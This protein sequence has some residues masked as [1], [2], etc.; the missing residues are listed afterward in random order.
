MNAYDQISVED[1]S[2]PINTL[3]NRLLAAG[4]IRESVNAPFLFADF[5]TI[6]LYSAN[7]DNE[8]GTYLNILQQPGPPTLQ[9]LDQIPNPRIPLDN[10]IRHRGRDAIHLLQHLHERIRSVLARLHLPDVH[11]ERRVVALHDF[12]PVRDGRDVLGE[13][14]EPL[15]GFRGRRCVVD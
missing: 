14:L 11:A 4:P 6:S 5:Y 15:G 7:R 1:G 2:S 8:K 12:Q 9:P 10:T 3:Y 13:G